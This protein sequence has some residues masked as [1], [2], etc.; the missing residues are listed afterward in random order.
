MGGWKLQDV[1][2]R[3]DAT[4]VRIENHDGV[5]VT[6]FAKEELTV[7][8][9]AVEQLLG[10]VA[11]EGTLR[12]L[13]QAER[14][15]RIDPFWGEAPGRLRAVVLTPDFHRGGDIPIGTVA[16]AERF[17]VPQA[18]GNDVGCGMRLLA[19]D[20][21]REELTPRLD[22]LEQRLRALFFQGQ[23][24]IPMSPRQREALLR[25][26]LPGLVRTSD[27]NAGAGTW[28]W[29]DAA[30]EQAAL[31]RTHLGGGLPA[32]GL[33]AF[34]DFVRGS[35]AGDGRDAQIGSVGGG[36]HFVELQWV[37]QIVD[38]TTSH[39]F[40]LARDGVAIMAHS[41][42][43]GL[44]HA[45]GGHFH[46]R[47]RALH[48]PALPRPAHGF[49]VLP[50]TGPHAPLAAAYLDAMRNAA[51]FAFGN[52][53]F[54]A[55]MMV[56]AL[57]EVLGRRVQTQLVYDAPHNLVWEEPDGITFVHRKGACPAPGPAPF[58]ESPFRYSGQPVIIPGSMGAHSFVLAGAGNADA[59]ESACHGA[60]RVLS[61][62]QSRRHADDAQARALERLRVVTPIDPRAYE[63]R[64]RR[65]VLAKYQDRLR[66]EAPWAYKPITPVVETVE[67]AAIARRVARLW[68]I[69]TV[70]G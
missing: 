12:A 4:R 27:D 17:V 29:Y 66:E 59:L 36:N 42:S 19:T 32:R 44:G 47:A 61:R 6:L 10:F 3:L 14:A 23:R 33:F 21:R 20:V 24:D 56:R 52:R 67:E 34:A 5:P 60:G 38:G 41:G 64:S 13:E 1:V 26:G 55:L 46:D 39:L 63:V 54:L 70:K 35:G 57:S 48:P 68:P 40:G 37:D 22:A 18:I 49:F 62:G 69:L 30:R 50:T 43:V 28:A 25:E 16:A 2:R 15:G 7:E 51:N 45:V 53:L 31:A 58:S 11:I 8:R 65:D 9:D